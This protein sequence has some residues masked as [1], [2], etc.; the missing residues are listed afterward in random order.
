VDCPGVKVALC[1]HSNREGQDCLPGA[2]TVVKVSV[3]VL[4]LACA[5]RFQYA[6]L[7]QDVSV[8]LVLSM[9]QA[10]SCKFLYLA[11]I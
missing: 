4:S 5:R 3:S 7:L 1:V 10:V 8:V 9:E 2:V 6:A 11:K